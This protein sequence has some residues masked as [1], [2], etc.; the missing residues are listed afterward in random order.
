M[1]TAKKNLTYLKIKCHLKEKKLRLFL[2]LSLENKFVSLL[3]L[4]IL[5]VYKNKN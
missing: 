5:V 4:S 1:I 3:V 2:I